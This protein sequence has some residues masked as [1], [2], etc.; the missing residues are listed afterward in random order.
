MLQYQSKHERYWDSKRWNRLHKKLK[1]SLYISG[2]LKRRLSGGKEKFVFNLTATIGYND[3]NKMITPMMI[4]ELQKTFPQR[5]LINKEFELE[6]FETMSGRFATFSEYLLGWSHLVGGNIQLAYAMHADIYNNKKQ[7]FYGHVALKDLMQV[8]HFEID[9]ILRE[10]K[11]HPKELVLECI[12]TAEQLFPNSDTATLMAAR[13]II[14]TCTD[15]TIFDSI[16]S[17]AQMLVGKA[18]MTDL[19]RDAVRVNRAY[20]SLLKGNYSKAETQYQK[21]F[22]KANEHIIGNVIE[23]CDEQIK[24]GCRKEQPTAYYVKA[25]MVA[26]SKRDRQYKKN[27]IELAI[28]NISIDFDY[29]HSKLKEMEHAICKSV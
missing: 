19:N 28:R 13:A 9:I 15:E 14:M 17:R 12:R 11:K 23:Y 22:D 1:G 2:T 27:T 6:E 3:V 21:F 24:D 25:L 8:L 10:C 16:S 5:V 29:Y 4:N 7:S 26:H 18:R 20:I